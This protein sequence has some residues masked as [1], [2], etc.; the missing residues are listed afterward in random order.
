MK[1]N[2]L[3]TA[4]IKD[5]EGELSAE[6]TKNNMQRDIYQAEIFKLKDELLI[7]Q[8]QLRK[9]DE[10][11]KNLMGNQQQVITIS[12][13]KA[14]VKILSGGIIKKNIDTSNSDTINA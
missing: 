10:I 5:L 11:I 3:L 1:K 9:S 14:K 7:T 6:K 2:S 13:E 4:K 8:G 12:G